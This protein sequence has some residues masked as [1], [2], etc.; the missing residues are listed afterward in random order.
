MALIWEELRAATCVVLR[1]WTSVVESRWMAVVLKVA[2]CRA[3]RD[4]TIDISWAPVR[5]RVASR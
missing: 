5:E 2:I 1:A 4:V 3:V